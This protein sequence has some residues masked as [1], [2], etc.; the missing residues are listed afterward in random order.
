MQNQEWVRRRPTWEVRNI[1]RALTYFS[2]LNTPE[3]AE[4]LRVAKDELQKRGKKA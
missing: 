2:F 4:R 1:A 3:E